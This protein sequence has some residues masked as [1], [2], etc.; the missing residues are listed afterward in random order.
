[1]KDAR[2]KKRIRY[3][4]GSGRLGQ[5]A[6]AKHAVVSHL[7]VAVFYPGHQDGQQAVGQPTCHAPAA[8]SRHQGFQ[9]LPNDANGEGALGLSAR[10][11]LQSKVNTSLK[12]FTK[13]KG[14]K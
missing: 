1:M 5:A 12:Y 8:R 2:R 7:C 14:Q 9:N 3:D 13:E 4:D 10:G 6:Q 11:F